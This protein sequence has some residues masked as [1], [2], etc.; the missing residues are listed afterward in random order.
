MIGYEAVCLLHFGFTMEQTGFRLLGSDFWS[1][2]SWVNFIW[3]QTQMQ[4]ITGFKHCL[5][6]LNDDRHFGQYFQ[7]RL[8]QET[9]NLMKEGEESIAKRI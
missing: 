6:T 5:F 3:A 2:P 7:S 9:E 4:Y 1:T 8:F